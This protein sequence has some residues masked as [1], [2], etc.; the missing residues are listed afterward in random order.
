MEKVRNLLLRTVWVLLAVFLIGKMARQAEAVE[1]GEGNN[2]FIFSDATTEVIEKYQI[3]EPVDIE[4]SE[5]SD[6]PV[7]FCLSLTRDGEEIELR[8]EKEYTVEV[9]DG[10]GMWMIY[11]YRI[12]KETFNEDGLYRLYLLSGDSKAEGE[13]TG[14]KALGEGKSQTGSKEEKAGAEEMPDTAIRRLEIVFSLDH[15]LKQSDDGKNLEAVNEE[16]SSPLPDPATENEEGQERGISNT[17]DQADSTPG[18]GD[19]G[20][21]DPGKKRRSVPIWLILYSGVLLLGIATIV[22]I[23]QRRSFSCKPA[24]KTKRTIGKRDRKKK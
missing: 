7:T 8:E 17:V 16:E 6:S 20:Q 10:D 19:D 9:R 15:T 23:S 5:I 12:Y 14:G 4:F 3:A 18:E 21:T 11:T 13:N 22:V 2:P 1:L 24:H